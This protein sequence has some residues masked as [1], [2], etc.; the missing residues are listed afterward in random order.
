MKTRY[1]AVENTSE[2]DISK[3]MCF[4]SLIGSKARITAMVAKMEEARYPSLFIKNSHSIRIA[5]SKR[6][7]PD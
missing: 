5:I 6:D 2:I 1:M 4:L 3:I 7:F